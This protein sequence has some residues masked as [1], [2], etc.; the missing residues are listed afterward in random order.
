MV[1]VLTQRIFH[2]R[3]VRVR[4]QISQAVYESLSTHIHFSSFRIH[5]CVWS[6]W[7]VT[8]ARRGI[9]SRDA[10]SRCRFFTVQGSRLAFC[11]YTKVTLRDV[12]IPCSSTPCENGATCTNSEDFATFSCTCTADY[13]GTNCETVIPCQ[14]NPCKNDGACTN[15]VDFSDF[16]CACRTEYSGKTCEEFLPCSSTPC[17]NDAVCI[18]LDDV[19][20]QCFCS[21]GFSGD[22]CSVSATNFIV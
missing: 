15:A 17:M 14:T 1:N 5:H 22:L 8:Q 3:L 4:Q 11:A 10:L 6:A 2:R 19:N 9:L 20:F 18:N 7:R 13:T 16:N 12:A 21:D